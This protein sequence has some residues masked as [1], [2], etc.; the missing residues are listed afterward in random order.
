[1]G[2]TKDMTAL[3]RELFACGQLPFASIAG[4]TSEMIDV[5][6]SSTHPVTRLNVSTTFGA[7]VSKMSAEEGRDTSLQTCHASSPTDSNLVDRGFEDL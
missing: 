4:E 2:F 3:E 7:F 1:M 5:I 6:T